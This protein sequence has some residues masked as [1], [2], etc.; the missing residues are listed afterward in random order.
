[1]RKLLM[2]VLAVFCVFWIFAMGVLAAFALSKN[3]HMLVAYCGLA[4]MTGFIFLHKACK[5]GAF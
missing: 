5:K 2:L 4:A 3:A 1:M